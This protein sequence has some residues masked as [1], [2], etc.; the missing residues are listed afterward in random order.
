MPPIF[1]LPTYRKPNLKPI[2][3]LKKSPPTEKNELA[4]N[5]SQVDFMVI[6]LFVSVVV[7]F[8]FFSGE[9]EE[10]LYC[11]SPCGLFPAP[12][13]RNAKAAVINKVKAKFKFLGKFMAKALMDSRMVTT[14]FIIVHVFVLFIFI[15]TW[16]RNPFHMI[17]YIIV[18]YLYWVINMVFGKKISINML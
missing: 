4:F 14:S 11:Y 9:D 8:V 2:H 1:R 7:R 18:I 5:P 6:V 3:T 10:T 17:C 15:S 16:N 13:P 12:L